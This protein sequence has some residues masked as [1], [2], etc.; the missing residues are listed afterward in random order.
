LIATIQDSLAIADAGKAKR[1]EAVGE[2]A[3]ME[4]ALKDTLAAA[5]AS[6]AK[7]PA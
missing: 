6:A 3:K 2:L 4:A 5:K 7:G 1:A